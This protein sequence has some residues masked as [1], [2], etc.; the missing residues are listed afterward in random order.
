MKKLFVLFLS[1][2][3]LCS[4]SVFADTPCDKETKQT[5]RTFCEKPCEKE[6]EPTCDK[7]LCT[8][9]DMEY[10][11]CNMHLSET[12][13]CNAKK[14]QSKY[15]QE[16]LSLNERIDCEKQK[17]CQLEKTCAKGSQIRKQKRLINKLEKKKKEICKCYEDQFKSTLSNTQKSAYRKY[18]K[19]K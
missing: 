15:E 19:C 13:I 11:F 3:C 14:L 16:V 17:L 18:K 2:I 8:N 12:Q 9:Q 6:I 10:L 7:F 4:L 1:F 5:P